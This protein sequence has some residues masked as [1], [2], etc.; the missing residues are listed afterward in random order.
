MGALWPVLIEGQA[1]HSGACEPA[2]ET[3]TWDVSQSQCSLRSGRVRGFLVQV[4]G[5]RSLVTGYL[6]TDPGHWGKH[7]ERA[8]DFCESFGVS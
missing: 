1:C 7:S 8:Y 4:S 6:S 2:R 5:P 3:W